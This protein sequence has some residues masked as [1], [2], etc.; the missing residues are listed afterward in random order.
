MTKETQSQVGLWKYKRPR[1]EEWVKY[2]LDGE[3]QE[4]ILDFVEWAREMGF[5]H[6]I[7]STSN[8]GHNIFYN[9]EYMCRMIINQ[10]ENATPAKWSITP[11]LI[12]LDK[13]AETV[14]NEG[15]E[16]LPWKLDFYCIYKTEP[17]KANSTCNACPIKG[18]TLQPPRFSTELT[19]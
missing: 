2:C 13:Y 15:L 16:K 17:C 6:K 9:K 7:H 8:R 14:I 19:L 10:K 5:K 12:H 4:Q 18:M 11:W 1:V 3:T